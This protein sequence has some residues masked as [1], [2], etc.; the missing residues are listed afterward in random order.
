MLLAAFIASA[1]TLNPLVF[2]STPHL[3]LL[4]TAVHGDPARDVILAGVGEIAAPGVPGTIAAWGDNAEVIVVGVE[5]GRDVPVVA[6]STMK[7]GRVV[8]FGHS[9]YFDKGAL[10]QGDTATLMMNAA[11]WAGGGHAT[12]T[13]GSKPKV[14]VVGAPDVVEALTKG[15]LDAAEL[16]GD[17]SS[18]LAT[19][20]VL[21]LAGDVAPEQMDAVRTFIENGGGFITAQTGWGWRQIH[22]GKEITELGINKLLAPGASIAYTDG[23]LEKTKGELFDAMRFP[24]KYSHGGFSLRATLAQ[25][26][27]KG[28]DARIA[29]HAA[30]SALRVLPQND[31]GYRPKIASLLETRK[32]HLVP[33]DAKPL[34]ASESPIDR[35][36]LAY[37]VDQ[38]AALPVDQVRAHPASAAFPGAVASDAPRVTRSVSISTKTPEWH[39]TGLYIPAGEV[40]TITLPENAS[41]GGLRAVIG[42]HTDE[43]WHHNEWHRVPRISS[44]TVLSGTTTKI[45][46]PYG[47]LLY[48]D[49]PGRA[50]GGTVEVSVAG[51]VEAPLFVLG[52]TSPDEWRAKIRNAPGP[53]AE[54]ATDRIIVTM[55]SSHVRDME[56]PTAVLEFW[57]KVMDADADL[58]AIPRERRRPERIVADVQISAGYMHSGY[59]IMTHLDAGAWLGN[60]DELRAGNWGLY[61]ELGHNHQ[62]GDWTFDGTVE[63][64]CNL[65]TLYVHDAVCD[66]PRTDSKK[67]LS[68]HQDAIAKHIALGAPFERWKSEPFTALAMY[69]QMQQ[70]FGWDS[71][72]KVF[73]E[74]GKLGWSQRPRS[75]DEKRDQWLVRYSRTVGRNLGPFFEKWGVPTSEKARDSIKDLP[76]WMPEGF[77]PR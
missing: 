34:H 71:F 67:W 52:K 14:G 8:L 4:H 43:L 11:K 28:D 55:P 64:T 20:G 66:I 38:L 45:A 40:V 23:Y 13:S 32:E 69:M 33:T 12:S 27:L 46:S 76:E 68:Q 36:L 10:S 47:G 70:E 59:P 3:A 19:V 21:V 48:I 72:K 74:Y 57:N 42:C 56:D 50:S 6:V 77:P 49:V 44:S 73:A 22:G 61:H 30:M 54:L 9:G 18:Q 65:F 37:Q 16:K 63:V 1:G 53:W 24:S 5:D 2:A 75:E 60:L 29:S 58:A 35:F 41:Q 51:A 31:A 17:W 39:S 26:E 25:E 62:E 7:K 15:G